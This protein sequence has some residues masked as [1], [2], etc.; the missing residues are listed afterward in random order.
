MVDTIKLVIKMDKPLHCKANF[1][2]SL[3]AIKDNHYGYFKAVCN[4][5][6]MSKKLGKYQPRLTYTQRPG[7]SYRASYE[8]QIEL[9]LPKIVYGNNFDE[10]QDKDLGVVISKLQKAMREMGVWLFTRML[11][12]AEVRAVHYSKNFVFTDYTSCSSVLQMLRT[13]DISKTYDVQ[14]TNFRNGGYVL[15][16]HTN[17]LDIAIYD[18]LADLQQSKKSEKRSQEKDN[19]VQMD[20]IELLK[21]KQPIA[22]M[23]YEVRLNGKKKI[24]TSL[25]AIGF[26]SPLTFSNLF[27]VNLAKQLLENHWLQFFRQYPKVDFGYKRTRQDISQHFAVQRAKRSNSGSCTSRNDAATKPKRAALH[28]N[29]L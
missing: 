20:M 29:A 26:N 6:A 1:Q 19:H 16:V 7:G 4:P 23:R 9:S 14:N 21:K 11:E 2:P 18:K 27:S 24:K 28:K 12:D 17:S 13:A 25:E 5:S 8:L 22:V 15:H 10:L 3:E